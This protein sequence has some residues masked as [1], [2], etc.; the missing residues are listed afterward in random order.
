MTLSGV[1]LT[2]LYPCWLVPIR[3]RTRPLLGH[4]RSTNEK[5]DPKAAQ[6][7]AEEGTRTLTP[8]NQN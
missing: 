5:G 3:G 7:V 8:F 2:G 4:Q 1:F 6:V